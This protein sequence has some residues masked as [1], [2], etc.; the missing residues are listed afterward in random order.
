MNDVMTLKDALPLVRDAYRAKIGM[1]NIVNIPKMYGF[2][3]KIGFSE[4][5]GIYMKEAWAFVA[6]GGQSPKEVMAE[7]R[8]KQRRLDRD[9]SLAPE[10][11]AKVSRAMQLSK[12][13]VLAE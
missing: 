7:F 9:G 4:F 13:A 2:L 10:D 6:Y 5:R 12:A 11:V 8:A 3:A 1:P